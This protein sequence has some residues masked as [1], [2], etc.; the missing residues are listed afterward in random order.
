[1]RKVIAVIAVVGLALAGAI[2]G[3][4]G[5]APAVDL[6]CPGHNANPNQ[7]IEA[8][9]GTQAGT[10]SF[11]P[12]AGDVICVKAGPGNTGV[13]VANGTTNLKDYLKAAGIVGGNGEGRDVSYFV[14]YPP[15]PQITL[16]ACFDGE[17]ESF[18][19][20]GVAAVEA[21]LSAFLA[22]NEG[23]VEANENTDCTEDEETTTTTAGETTTTTNT[24]PLFVETPPGPK[25]C[26]VVDANGRLHDAETGRF[27]TPAPVVVVEQA[28]VRTAP[29]P[30]ALP[31][32]V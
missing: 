15:N 1:M 4:A 7:K 18:G 10:N 8:T 9:G 19:P 6:H 5:A 24:A 28:P 31:R 30:V 17:L 2:N 14:E 25:G 27:C 13:F 32:T 3:T 23:S 22:D 21:Q 11:V 20:G 12:D 16:Y 29:K 26:V